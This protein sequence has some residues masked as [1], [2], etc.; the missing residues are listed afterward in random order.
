MKR[1]FLVGLLAIMLVTFVG[2]GA[3][4]TPW[5][6]ATV[7]TY[8]LLGIGIGAA[9]DT[10]ESL[11]VQNLISAEQVLKIKVVYSK[12]REA[13]IAAGNVL[14]LAGQAED[15][16]KRDSLLADYG[17]LLTDFKNLSIQLYDLVKSFKKVSLNDVLEMVR[18][19]GDPCSSL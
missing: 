16:I 3:T 6:K 8:E 10:T 1:I 13:F 15:S 14:K 9:K 19:G 18:N 7:D 2:C 17:K 11:Q 12:A 4:V 5:R